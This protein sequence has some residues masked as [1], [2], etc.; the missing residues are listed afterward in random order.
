MGDQSVV[1]K[2]RSSGCLGEGA[3]SPLAVV[4]LMV[5]LFLGS[6]RSTVIILVNIP[7]AILVLIGGTVLAW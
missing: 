1:V 4:G 3:T 2:P 6:W 7:L 5:L